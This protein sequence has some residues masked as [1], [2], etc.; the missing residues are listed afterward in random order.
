MI[1]LEPRSRG[2]GVVA[3]G[4]AVETADGDAVLAGVGVVLIPLQSKVAADF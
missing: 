1:L 3:G 4:S 2:V